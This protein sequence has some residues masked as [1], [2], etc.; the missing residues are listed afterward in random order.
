MFDFS[1]FQ[2]RHSLGIYEYLTKFFL[3]KRTGNKN[4]LFSMFYTYLVF[5]E[6]PR[7]GM[8]NNLIDGQLGRSTLVVLELLEPKKGHARY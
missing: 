3:P 2:S 7:D 4:D 8:C 6:V 1:Q 5:H